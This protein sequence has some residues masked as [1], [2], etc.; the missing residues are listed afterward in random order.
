MCFSV[1]L[2][3][4]HGKQVRHPFTSRLLPIITD[5]TVDMELGTGGCS[6]SKSILEH[7]CC[8]VIS[9][10]S[11]KDAGL[12]IK[13]LVCHRSYEGDPCSWPCGLPAVSETLAAT[14]VC[15]WGRRE[16]EP[17]VW[18]VAAG[19]CSRAVA[20]QLWETYGSVVTPW[21]FLQGVRRFDARQLVVDALAEKKLFRGEKSHAMTLPVCR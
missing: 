10:W 3:A 19:T 12:I 13:I 18:A 4:F 1:L 5:P 21:S 15:D 11:H 9:A 6:F 7:Q 14:P 8:C 20:G 16:D 2:K 17:S